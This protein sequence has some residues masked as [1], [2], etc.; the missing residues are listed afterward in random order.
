MLGQPQKAE[1]VYE[2]VLTL[3]VRS[4]GSEHPETLYAMQIFAQFYYSIPQ[5][6]LSK[7]RTVRGVRAVPSARYSSA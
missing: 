2:R 1:T 6:L 3:R 7:G 5:K 4:W